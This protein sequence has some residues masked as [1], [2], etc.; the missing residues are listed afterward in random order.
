MQ[1]EAPGNLTGPPVN[2]R[3]SETPDPNPRNPS[4]DI[5]CAAASSRRTLLVAAQGR[6]GLG[7]S[8]ER[9]DQ[10]AQ[11]DRWCTEVG[12]LRGWRNTVGNLIE[13]LLAQTNLSPASFYGY[14]RETR[15]ATVSSNSR[16]QRGLFRQYSANL[17]TRC[18][19]TTASP[20]TPWSARFRQRAPPPS[21]HMI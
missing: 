3:L 5:S 4:Q 14:M 17:S 18:P 8:T 12:E 13:V 19:R 20:S 2:S 16:F 1:T 10:H 9:D 11:G 6:H 7:V 15:R 21:V